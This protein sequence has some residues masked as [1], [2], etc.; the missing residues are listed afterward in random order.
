MPRRNAD[1]HGALFCNLDWKFD[2]C[3]RFKKQKWIKVKENLCKDCKIFFIFFAIIALLTQFITSLGIWVHCEALSTSPLTPIFGL[4]FLLVLKAFQKYW[5]PRPIG[6]LFLT[7]DQSQQRADSL[8]CLWK[9]IQSDSCGVARQI[10][11]PLS[12][13]KSQG[14]QNWEMLNL[15]HH[16]CGQR[17]GQGVDRI[18]FFMFFCM[19]SS[20]SGFLPCFFSLSLQSINSVS[21]SYV[22]FISQNAPWHHAATRRSASV[23]QQ[24]S[25]C[26]RRLPIFNNQCSGDV[27]QLSPLTHETLLSGLLQEF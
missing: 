16:A 24:T 14:G 22:I 20:Q 11:L 4:L 15:L 6:A 26:V 13:E 17:Q 8:G 25:L 12:S 27:I 9:I 7:C 10:F 1:S 18:R 2:Q 3:A 19:T 5:Q 23:L 21:S